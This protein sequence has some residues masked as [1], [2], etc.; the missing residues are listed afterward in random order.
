MGSQYDVPQ[1]KVFRDFRIPSSDSNR[2]DRLARRPTLPDIRERLSTIVLRGIL[3]SH[4]PEVLLHPKGPFPRRQR[5]RASGW[6]QSPEI[7]EPHE[8]QRFEEYLD[9]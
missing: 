6:K 2:N 4:V 3:L 9:P 1:G 8:H 7:P 5:R